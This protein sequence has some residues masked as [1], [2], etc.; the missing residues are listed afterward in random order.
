MNGSH[1]RKHLTGRA[2]IVVYRKPDAVTEDAASD[3]MA[4]AIAQCADDPLRY[5]LFAFPWGEVGTPLAK[6]AG[7]D[8]WQIRFLK[9]LAVLIVE[10]RIT[11]GEAIKMAVA[12]GHGI[13]KSACIAWIILWFLSTRETPQVV[14]TANTKTQL[15]TK[16]WREVGKWLKLAINGSWFQKT[17][18][19]VSLKD[20]PED[21]YALAQPWSKESPE[22]FA[23]THETNVLFLFDEGSNIPDV[24]WEV[25][26]GAMTTAGAIWIVFGNPTRN[27]GRFRECWREFRHR[28]VTFEIDS[29]TAKMAN[30]AQLDAWVKDYG[31]DSDFVRIR[32]KGEFPRSA[33][34]QLIGEDLVHA[35]AMR[36]KE[37]LLSLDP[38]RAQEPYR[39]G[40]KILS[41]DVARFG[42]D[43]SVIG[44]REGNWFEI[45]AVH[46]GLDSIQLA[47]RVGEWI[48]KLRP[49]ATFLDEVGV[50]AGALDQLR[51]LGY[52][53]IGVNGAHSA[54]DDKVNSNKRAEMWVGMRDWLKAGGCIPDIKELRSD[55]TAPEY[56]YDGK[57]RI[58]LEKKEDMKARGIPSPDRGDCLSMTFYMP[59]AAKASQEDIV[60]RFTRKQA[61]AS[62]GSWMAG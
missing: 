46:Q 15:E 22:S 17:N 26:E 21:W 58:Q 34:N 20:Q 43:E 9:R 57:D 27:T 36:H 52:D 45:L 14:C 59:V 10:R 11:P 53:V 48:S 51:H 40:A 13:G 29:R 61:A 2:F 35:A 32:V 18:T 30:R 62:G 19:K 44:L 28:W 12:S 16:T 38:D 39:F 47:F 60:A 1:V 5:V 56:G 8:E 31:E 55:L 7:P 6:Q 33:S 25:V 41:I 4:E 23:G 37:A 42:T 24:I 3:E 54:I 50:G 49:D